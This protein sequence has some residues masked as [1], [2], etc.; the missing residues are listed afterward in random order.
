[1]MPPR[2]SRSCQIPCS[3]LLLQGFLLDKP[4]RTVQSMEANYRFLFL[5]VTV[6]GKAVNTLEN[7]KAIG[8]AIHQA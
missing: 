3:K 4:R 8:G 2:K 6:S 1:M 7:T 5:L